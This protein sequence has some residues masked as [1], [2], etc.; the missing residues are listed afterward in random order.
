MKVPQLVYPR[1]L[2]QVSRVFLQDHFE[3]DLEDEV[4]WTQTPPSHQVRKGE[5]VVLECH[6]QD[7]VLKQDSTVALTVAL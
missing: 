1:V 7:R 6:A 2:R 4:S 5:P 3:I